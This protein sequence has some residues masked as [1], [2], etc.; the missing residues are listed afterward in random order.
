MAEDIE[1]G[2]PG[3]PRKLF[4]WP[5]G[6]GGG[7]VR[8]AGER[9]DGFDPRVFA[10]SFASLIVFM[11]LWEVVPRYVLPG[12][13]AVAIRPFSTVCAEGWRLLLDGT[14]LNAIWMSSS[15]VMVGF[16]AAAAVAIPAGIAMGTSVTIRAVL[17]PYVAIV[18]PLPSVAW[19]PIVMM[20]VGIGEPAKWGII[21]MG[22]L[23]PIL[24]ATIEATISVDPNLLR[25]AQNLGAN[26][27]QVMFRV[28]L[29]AALPQIL[30][31][32]KVAFAVAWTCIIS[33]EFVATSKGLGA[34]MFVAKDYSNFAQVVV[35]M[36]G[37]VLIVTLLDKVLN[38][39]IRWLLPWQEA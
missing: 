26:R 22:A 18:R 34:Q 13:W 38:L 28:L 16:L 6:G 27:R 19:I 4:W 24:V 37:I 8:P 14:L 20:I 1:G 33:A 5:K 3:K 29:P 9:V 32:L 2:R 35:Y 25:A 15:R 12:R 11:I 30:S 31:G 21:F 36:A 7:I 39:V 23:A 10:I 17:A